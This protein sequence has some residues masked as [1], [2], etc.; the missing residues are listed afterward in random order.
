MI[1]PKAKRM[2]R[3]SVLRGAGGVAIAL[4]FL[5]IMGHSG[6]VSGADAATPRRLVIV[7]SPHGRAEASNDKWRPQGSGTDFTLSEFHTDFLPFQDQMV[8]LSGLRMTSAASQSG[9]GHSK[10]PTH[11]LTCT[12]H[13][14]ET[15]PGDMSMGT[16]GFAGGISIDQKIAS[17]LE[18]S[19]ALEYPSLQFGVQSG[20]DFAVNGAT[21]RSFI[22][23]AGPGEPIPA[24]DSP[25]QMF[26]R[27]FGDFSQDSAE[28]EKL[29]AERRS[30]L[31]LVMEDFERLDPK[32][33]A[34]DSQR[35]EKHL[36]AIREIE[37]SID[38][39]N[40]T[41]PAC[42]VPDV[43]A[44]VEAF[45]DNDNFP[46]VG[47]QQTKLLTMALACDMTR[48][49]TFQ[50]STGQSTTRHSWIDGAGGKAHHGITHDGS[51]S[52]DAYDAISKWYAGRVAE[53]LTQ[54]QSTPDLDGNSLLDNT[55]V[56][57]IAGEMAFADAHNFN[58][59]PYV[60]FGGGAGTINT[61]QHLVFDGRAHN[62]LMVTIQQ[63]MGIEDDI[64]GKPDYVQGPLQGVLV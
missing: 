36:D 29:R 16:I 41:N 53:L 6:K 10:G 43:G 1:F 42:E 9:N 54:L 5:E 2:S 20:T 38:L 7:Y 47:E 48:V 14:D 3:R 56:L 58:D 52:R 57:W 37:Q 30:V 8:V 39:D 28:L 55:I 35:V 11:A 12:D 33:G 62:D 40:G 45:K 27:L 31:D 4:P 34:Q 59:M 22:S 23:Y 19:I 50:W 21:T 15:I 17:F 32:L 63:A 13:L 25:A 26:D 49:A 61:G 44:P 60:L 18:E 46:L 64:F 24:E 51:A